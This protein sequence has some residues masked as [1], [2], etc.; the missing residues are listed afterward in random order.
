MPSTTL[1]PVP[2]ET[3][4]FAPNTIPCDVRDASTLDDEPS[5]TSPKRPGAPGMVRVRCVVAVAALAP[6]YTVTGP[7]LPSMA[8]SALAVTYEK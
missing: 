6:A 8:G 4:V 7:A 1:S 3:R 5:G 2:L